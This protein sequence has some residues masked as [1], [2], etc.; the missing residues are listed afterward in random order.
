MKPPIFIDNNGDLAVFDSVRDAESWIEPIDVRSNE[1]VAFDSEGRLLRLTVRKQEGFLTSG[2]EYVQLAA[3]ESEPAHAADLRE[4]LQSFLNVA[5]V[6]DVNPTA[7]LKQLVE[8]ARL[9]VKK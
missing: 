2:N 7:T 5:G 4:R 3:A 6:K 1:Y 9:F 8:T